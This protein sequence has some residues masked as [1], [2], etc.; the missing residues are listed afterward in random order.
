[1]TEC[2]KLRQIEVARGPIT[3]MKGDRAIDHPVPPHAVTDAGEQVSDDHDPRTDVGIGPNGVPQH[4]Q[5]RILAEI[6]AQMMDVL[7]VQNAQ[8]NQ[9][10]R[11]L[12]A[13]AAGETIFHCPP[14]TNGV[15]LGGVRDHRNGAA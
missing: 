13:E 6:R 7:I 4:R 1:M 10:N 14:D 12:N 11:A 9:G 2:L 5:T 15:P 8:G 3:T